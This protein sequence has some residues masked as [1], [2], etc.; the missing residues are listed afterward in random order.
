MLSICVIATSSNFPVYAAHKTC[1]FMCMR[2]CVCVC[3]FCVCVC[4]CCV[5]PYIGSWARLCHSQFRPI[6]YYVLLLHWL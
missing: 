1:M 6:Y 5:S 2:A 4:V 3:I